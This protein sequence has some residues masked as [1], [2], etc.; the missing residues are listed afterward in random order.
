MPKFVLNF[1]VWLYRLTRGVVGGNMP[2]NPVLLLHSQG[3]KSGKKYVTPLS[4]FRDDER[5]L[6]VGSNWG[7]D[8]HAGW[9]YNLHAEPRT[10]IEVMGSTISVTSHIAEGEEY[11]RLWSAI[12][13]AAQRYAQYQQQTTR[14]IPLI[15]LVPSG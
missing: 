3:R 4:Y 12:T 5:Y 13:T 1:H 15:V 11:D 8:H 9:Y 10:T 2:G 14:T 7:K 6:V